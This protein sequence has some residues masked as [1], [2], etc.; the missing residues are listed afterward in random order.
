MLKKYQIQYLNFASLSEE[1]TE[2]LK[3]LMFSLYTTRA[4]CHD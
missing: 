1:I 3:I 2:I 4:L